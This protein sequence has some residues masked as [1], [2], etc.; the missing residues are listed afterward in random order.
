M[1]DDRG[2]ACLQDDL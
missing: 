1:A 2:T